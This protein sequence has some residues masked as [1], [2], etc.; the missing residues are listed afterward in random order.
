MYLV[1]LEN[2]VLGFRVSSQTDACIVSGMFLL[3]R[4]YMVS[5]T[6]DGFISG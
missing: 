3:V 5:I 1:R 6:V 2:Q 4:K